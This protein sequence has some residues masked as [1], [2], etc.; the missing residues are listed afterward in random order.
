MIY[1]K[2]KNDEGFNKTSSSYRYQECKLFEQ[3]DVWNS[4]RAY[5]KNQILACTTKVKNE[6]NENK[7]SLGLQH[8]KVIPKQKKKKIQDNLK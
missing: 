8:C 3:L 5:V 2:Y 1:I 7:R 4:T 6:N